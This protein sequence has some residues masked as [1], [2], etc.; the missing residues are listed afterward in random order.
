MIPYGRQD[1]TASD[2]DAVTDVLTS[3]FLTQGPAVPK[4][5]AAICEATDANFAVAV[6]SAT[7]ALHIAYMALDLGPGDIV[8]TC[9]NTFVA[10]ANAALYCGADVDFVDCDPRTYNLSAAALEQK[11]KQARTTPKIVSV[12]HF[13]GQSAEMKAIHELSQKYGFRIVEDASHA[14]GGRYDGQPVGNCRY[15]DIC[16]F[17]F[18]P[19]K[20][21][22]TAEGGAATTQD[23]DLATKME[24]ARSHGVTRRTDLMLEKDPEPW[25]YEQLSLGYNYRMTDL[26]A[27]LGISQIQRLSEYVDRRHEIGRAYDR[28]LADLP[29]QLPYQDPDQHSALHLYPIQVLKHSRREVF[30]AL[31]ADGIGV[32]VHYIPVHTQPYY[33]AKGF[34]W[35]DFPEAE[36]YYNRAISLPMFP[37][38]KSQE[39]EFVIDT[40][41]KKLRAQNAG[42]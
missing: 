3:P 20:I 23:K 27:A 5:E 19:V 12:V 4:F 38:I 37:A 24:L 41:H 26:Q 40:V 6:N 1:I 7:S 25:V 32:N 30:D 10:T 33:R 11:L 9:P 35:G 18:H 36:T 39:L 16:V 28:A 14:I 13:A 29:V 8:W 17:S 15:S 31:R 34:E 22:T 21:V 42:E 2:I